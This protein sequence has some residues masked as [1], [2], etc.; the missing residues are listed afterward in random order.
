MV[1]KKDI[2][3]IAGVSTST[4]SNFF[5][6]K[7]KMSLE[8][9][10]RIIDAA[11]QLNYPLS[12]NISNINEKARNVFLVVNDIT[13]MHYSQIFSG[14]QSV[15]TEHSIVVS[16]LQMWNDADSFFDTIVSANPIAVFF[17]NSKSDFSENHL[18]L[19]E[20]NGILTFFALENLEIDY[21]SLSYQCI[22][23]LAELGHTRI[24]FLSGLPIHSNS[25]Y[26]FKAFKKALESN[27][28]PF[29]EEL[30]ID[31]IY[32]YETTA[33]SGYLSTM[34]FLKK[35]IDFSAIVSLN[36][37]LAIGIIDAL[38]ESGLSV[39][40]DVSVIGCDDIVI[41]EHINPP[42]TTFN[43]SA[44]EVGSQTMFLIMQKL[45]DPNSVAPYIR[46]KTEFIIRHSTGICK[47]NNLE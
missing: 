31:G 14:M 28:L 36:D 43:T 39:P 1:K 47:K 42:L 45:N 46:L 3:K 5:S 21:A 2:A 24:A 44:F 29:Y 6:G 10:K 8:T 35:N 41:A 26:R 4:V 11:K 34:S 32:P 37:M 7:P 18:K 27:N 13:N 22:K 17:T 25:N 19:L 23:Y 9:Q 38:T 15:A 33:K 12:D 16:M 30:A 20:S 40:N